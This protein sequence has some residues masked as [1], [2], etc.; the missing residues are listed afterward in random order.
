MAKVPNGVETLPK[1]S[2]AWVGCTNVTDRRQRDGRTT[3]YSE[4]SRSLKTLCGGRI[5]VWRFV[6]SHP[7]G[8]NDAARARVKVPV[9][10]DSVL[11]MLAQWT[12]CYRPMAWEL[13][14]TFAI[15]IIS[16]ER[17]GRASYINRVGLLWR[18]SVW[19]ACLQTA[20][21]LYGAYDRA[22]W[23]AWCSS[24]RTCTQSN[25]AAESCVSG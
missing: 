23:D 11:V 2:I 21:L 24:L 10:W 19:T 18:V 3:T 8:L 4:S 13:L 22:M 1:I 5:F 25:A 6:L 7:V 15:R 16:E 9:D 12:D 17:I 14:K 20:I